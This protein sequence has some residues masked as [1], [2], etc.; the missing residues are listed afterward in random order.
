MGCEA[1][2][3]EKFARRFNAKP[4]KTL[5]VGSKCYGEKIDRRELYPDA[6]GL[7][8]FEGEGVDFV[9]DLEKPLRM[10]FD[11]VDCVSVLEHVRRP[12][13]MAENIEKLL[14]KDGTLLICVPFVWRVHAYPSDFWRMTG[15]ALEILFPKIHWV[16]RRYLVEG[17]AKRG[18]KGKLDRQGQWMQRAELAAWGIKCG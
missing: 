14:V 13:K 5:V 17:K 18:V 15:E 3:L 12:W 11:H 7:D 6:V 9:H 1:R 2:G 8:L 16:D 4:G 10:R